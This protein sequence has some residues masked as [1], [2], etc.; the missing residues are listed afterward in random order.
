MFQEN[1]EAALRIDESVEDMTA[2]ETAPI[3][4]ADTNGGVRYCS[5]RGSVSAAASFVRG[6][7][8]VYPALVKSCRKK[9]RNNYVNSITTDGTTGTGGRGCLPSDRVLSFIGLIRADRQ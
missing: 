7:V 9:R 3:P 8:P 6:T 1:I 4:M 5:T 2:A